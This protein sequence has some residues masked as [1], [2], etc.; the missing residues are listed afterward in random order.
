MALNKP[1]LITDLK[2][3][4]D[5]GSKGVYNTPLSGVSPL[6][7][8]IS[9]FV[10]EGQD[11]FGNKILSF[12]GVALTA[13]LL[14][15]LVPGTALLG[16]IK[17]SVGISLD[18]TAAVLEVVGGPLDMVSPTTNLITVPPIATSWQTNFE[19]VFSTNYNTS[20]LSATA[21]ANTIDSMVKSSVSTLT[22]VQNIPLVFPT[23]TITSSIS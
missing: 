1:K 23:V 14:L 6:V 22:Y 18:L 4:M 17:F 13:Q 3:W 12:T 9:N 15:L 16:A 20:L 5:D 21:L 19:T 2:K 7:L 11:S 8:I 10:S